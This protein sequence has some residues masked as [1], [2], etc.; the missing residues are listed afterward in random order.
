[1]CYV[2]NYPVTS[3]ATYNVRI[4]NKGGIATGGGSTSGGGAVRILWGTGRSFPSTNVSSTFN[5]L[6]N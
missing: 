4:G 2:N 3:G 5:E 1:L 6:T